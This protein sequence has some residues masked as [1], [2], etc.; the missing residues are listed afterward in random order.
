[1]MQS[2]PSQCLGVSVFTDWDSLIY[3]VGQ[4][5][6]SSRV[7][8]YPLR[9]GFAAETLTLQK[10]QSMPFLKA[11]TF[12]NLKTEHQHEEFFAMALE[13]FRNRNNSWTCCWNHN[14]HIALGSNHT[15]FYRQDHCQA[16]Q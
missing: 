5:F 15:L 4:D 6:Y 16:I 12:T 8:L 13:R 9:F 11:Q 1:M 10:K 14:L 2:A 3:V 7:E